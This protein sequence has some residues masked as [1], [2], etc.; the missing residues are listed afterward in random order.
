MSGNAITRPPLARPVSILVGLA[1]TFIVM[2]GLQSTS[3]IIGPA[4][5]AL[6]LTIA[7]HPL[8]GWVEARGLPGWVGTVAGLAAVYSAL[9]VLV[10]SFA[11]AM[12]RFATLLPTYRRQMT[13]LLDRT[14]AWLAGLGLNQ[15]QLEK[16]AGALDVNKLVAVAGSVAG[17][18]LGVLTGLGFVVTLLIFMIADSSGFGHKLLVLPAERLPLAR[19]MSTFASGV[20]RYVVV[21]AVFGFAVALVDVG[22]LTVIGIPVPLVWGLLAFITH[23]IPNVGFLVGLIPPAVI[24]LL[25]GGPRTM[26]AVVVAY[27]VINVAIET[28][29]QPKIVGTVVGLSP[30]LT[31]LSLVV[32]AFTL[33][34]LGAL[35]A[36]PLTLLVKAFLVDADPGAEW[37]QPLLS[38]PARSTKRAPR[39]PRGIARRERRGGPEQDS[40]R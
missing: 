24:G 2:A 18:V 9:L 40:G 22:A 30:I 34:V 21:S 25:Q 35:L 12:A 19:A 5:L 32:W 36:V 6:V 13:D 7:V 29:L 27:C 20:R 15:Q 8:H 1:A 10:V 11:V 4:F 17:S 38:T 26:V 3:A 23:F 28:V 14:L 16:M 39:L 31:M 33:G 37:L